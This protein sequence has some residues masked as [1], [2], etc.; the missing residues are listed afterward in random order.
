MQA[1]AGVYRWLQV[2]LCGCAV[3]AGKGSLFARL[4][5]KPAESSVA[6][7][8]RRERRARVRTPARS[9]VEGLGSLGP[10]PVRL[11]A[12]GSLKDS[13]TAPGAVRAVLNASVW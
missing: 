9:G 7:V 11:R 12:R 5:A 10:G 3:V 1:R 6:V 8:G 2:C 4:E 13:S